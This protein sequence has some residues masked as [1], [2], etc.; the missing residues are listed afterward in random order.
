MPGIAG[1]ISKKP[2]RK[3]EK[4][5]KKMVSCMMHEHFYKS[6]IYSNTNLNIST[7]WVTIKNSFADCMP[8]VNGTKDIV[9]IYTGENF[10]DTD[11]S[12]EFKKNIKGKSLSSAEYLVDLYEVQGDNFFSNLN[13]WFSGII[14]D[15]RK[16][17]V[18]IF[19]D[20]YGLNR[21]YYHYNKDE[22]IFSSEAKAILNIRSELKN[23]NIKCLGE[24]FAF[25]CV[26]NNK[27][28]FDKIEILPGGSMMTWE[29]TG[30]FKSFKYF[31]YNGWEQQEKLDEK[32]FDIEL[33]KTFKKI[34]PRYFYS[35]AQI[36]V[37]M[38]G[39]L[40]TRALLSYEKISTET[41]P[42]Y[43]FGGIYRDCYDV[44]TARKLSKLIDQ[45]YS[46]LKLE[47][48]FFRNFSNLAEKTVYISDG[49]HDVCGTHDLY[50][51]RLAREI[52]PV[53]LTGKFGSEVLRGASTFKELSLDKNMFDDEIYQYISIAKNK[54]QEMF[55]PENLTFT[56]Y[57]DIPNHEYGRLA[58]EKSQLTFR[59]PYLDNELV[60]LMYR[61]PKNIRNNKSAT[62]RLIGALDSRLLNIPTD[63]G[64][65]GRANTFFSKLNRFNRLVSFKAEW[66]F[67]E[68]MPHWLSFYNKSGISKIE[69]DILGKHK[70]EHYRKWFKEDLAGY[71]KDVL[72]DE[73]TKRRPF[74]NR[75][76]IERMVKTHVAGKRNYIKEINKA[77]TVELIHKLFVDA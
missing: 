9:L 57:E 25:G 14:F 76:F 62:L 51:N 29:K 18:F 59:T 20:R 39:G 40:D 61:A 63:L 60:E 66:F 17:K 12:E 42:F 65:D 26:L 5:V 43:T 16:E 49:C 19:N 7:G 23:V 44:K 56:C 45:H 6:G 11:D 2:I 24:Y 38:T 21:I 64:I 47:E 74:F 10:I 73:N 28:L 4:D 72:L 35:K 54:Y 15:L 67:N 30:K 31:T 13:G 77:V 48:S 32:S 27:T 50:Y 1:I 22:L 70:I 3:L 68:G 75:K 53:R 55:V 8:V 69:K 46:V 37:S 33:A 36:G 71:I 58:V 34:L 52:A 41:I